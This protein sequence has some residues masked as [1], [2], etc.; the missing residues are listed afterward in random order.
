MT[1]VICVENLV[2]H[3]PAF[4]A[5]ND[6]S[7]SIPQGSIT[8]LVGPNGAGKS[9][10]MRCLAGLDTPFSGKI[11]VLDINILENRRLGHTKIG[12]LPDNFGLYGDLTVTHTLDFIAGCH[13]ITGLAFKTR[14]AA[15]TALLRLESVMDKKCGELSRGWRQRVGIA[16]AIIHDPKLLILDEP[17]SGLD[18]E[19]RSDLSTILKTL[20]A[21]GMTIMVSSHILAELEE[22][23]TAMLVIRG[24]KIINHTSLHDHITAQYVTLIASFLHTPTAEQK[25]RIEELYGTL[26]APLIWHDHHLTMNAPL[27]GQKQH[28]ILSELIKCGLSVYKFAAE[29]K[30]LQTLYLEMAHQKEA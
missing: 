23:C 25:H 28:E 29:E 17:A 1:N 30:S 16:M 20:Q 21:Q 6:I 22:Y 18:P 3:Y 10:L 8:A 12:F 24:G 26:Y 27:D 11:N 19:A 14:L 4:T 2:Y 15:L 7:F 5:L 9:T 13:N